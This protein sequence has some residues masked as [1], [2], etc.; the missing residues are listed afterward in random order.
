M[1]GT[2]AYREPVITQ[3]PTPTNLFRFTGASNA[4]SV[5][6]NAGLPVSF[7][8]RLN[9][10]AIPA[11]TNT[12]YQLA[13][14]Q[15]NHSGNY[16]VVVSNVF[17]VV[18]S[19]IVSLTVVPSPTY[20]FGQAVLSDG[21]IGFWR[22]DES[23][24]TVAHDY[25]S[26]N[27][28][29]YTA[30][31]LGQPGYKLVDT[32]TS[33]RFGILAASNSCVTNIAVDFA[34]SGNAAF[35]VEAW[36][37]GGSQ[38]TDA[39]LV[40][41]GYGSGGEQFNLDCGGGGH[42]FRFFVRDGSGTARLATSSV[43]PN[44]QWHH[45]VGVCDQANG[46][47][48]LYVDGVNVAQGTI[49]PNSGILSSASPVSIGSR[50]AGLG[51]AYNNQFVGYMEEVAIYGYALSANQVLAHYLTATN[52]APV[53][54]SNPLTLT[55]ANAGQIYVATLVTSTSDPNGDSITFA[56][57][58]G[59]SW[60]SVGSNGSLS[61]TPLSSDVGTNAFLVSASDP[62][63]LI[64]STTMNV[65]VIAAPPI[66][67][68]VGW[69]GNALLLN[70]TGGIAPYQMQWATNLVNPT[71]QNLGAPVGANSLS[72]FPTNDAAFYRVSGQ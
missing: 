67:L 31:V 4:W 21:P 53:F 25:L 34:T 17:G 59:P 33:A 70:W 52:R 49:T 43:V 24:G 71:W 16:T 32:H 11:A 38:T 9:G 19:S 61:G 26:T 1:S 14:M 13:N 63:G 18:T 66:I 3:Q 30:A 42:A 51:T 64:T 28:G 15:T 54:T 65:A 50:Q 48:R 37:N 8:W 57:V 40:T 44:N 20:P 62:G 46:L 27:N 55:S 29:T 60:L 22:L 35:S 39:G 23:S 10:T 72:V 7:S 36:V 69:Q 12:T 47:V 41:K 2:V 5:A 58:S 56:K 45:L 68:S 6:V